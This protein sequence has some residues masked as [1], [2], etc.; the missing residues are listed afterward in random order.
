M[1]LTRN[2]KLGL[3]AMLTVVVVIIAAYSVIGLSRDRTGQAR[4][5]FTGMVADPVNITLEELKSM[6]STTVT[7]ELICVDGQS[8]GVHN[9]TGV[10]LNYL[11][12]ERGIVE[13]AI[14]VAFFAD[15]DYSTDLTIGDANREDVLIAY[16][17]DGSPMEEGTKLVVPGKWGYKWISGIAEIRLVDYNFMGFWE[18]RGYSD[19]ATI[20]S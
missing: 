14:K 6:P 16:L 17:K 15:D 4:I 18:G 9:W 20:P 3:L 1:H 13:G 5:S 10:K 19:D 12:E 7:S 2:D 8:L 11:L